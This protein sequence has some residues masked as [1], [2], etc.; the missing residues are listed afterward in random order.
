MRWWTN[1]SHTRVGSVV[2]S[3]D[4]LAGIAVGLAAWQGAVHSSDIAS[5]LRDGM[6]TVMGLAVAVTAVVVAAHT[7]F[8]SLT[9]PAYIEVL[10]QAPGGLTAASHPYKVTA[11]VSMAA[12]VAAVFA[13]VWP[14]GAGT[15]PAVVAIPYWLAAWASVGMVQLIWIGAAHFESREMVNDVVRKIRRNNAA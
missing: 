5:G 8:I 13:L 11:I 10:K 3:P 1:L 2:L 7:L 9:S 15:P 12:I 14:V 6:P 4:S